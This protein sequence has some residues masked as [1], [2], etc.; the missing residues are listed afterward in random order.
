MEAGDRDGGGGLDGEEA[1]VT[2]VRRGS[3]ERGRREEERQGWREKEV[4]ARWEATTPRMG[5]ERMGR[6]RERILS[7]R[8]VLWRSK[9]RRRRRATRGALEEGRRHRTMVRRG[10]E[11]RCGY[12]RMTAAAARKG[13]WRRRLF[14]AGYGWGHGKNHVEAESEERRTGGGRTR[15]RGGGRRTGQEENDIPVF[16]RNFS[17]FRSRNG[18]TAKPTRQTS[19]L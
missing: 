4:A 9:G 13:G 8:I 14:F 17:L 10:A 6:W 5:T 18:K 15:G 19:F 11:R 2:T 3:G 16:S 7:N 1:G 12:G